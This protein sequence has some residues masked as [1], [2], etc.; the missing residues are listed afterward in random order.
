M[1]HRGSNNQERGIALVSSILFL[2]VVTMISVVAASNS[3]STLQMSMNAQDTLQSFQAAEA[4][5]YAAMATV[6]TDDDLF[7]GNDKLGVFSSMNDEGHPLTLLDHGRTSVDADVVV[8]SVGTACPRKTTSSS[9]GL[10]DCDYYRIESQHAVDRRANTRV[11][12]GVV[13]T[14]IGKNVR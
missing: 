12:M 6:G 11:N 7:T 14:V 1:N 2:L 5:V 8:T 4:G 10:L 9:V 13:K 3:R